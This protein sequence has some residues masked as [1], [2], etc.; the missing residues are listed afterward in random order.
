ISQY[1]SALINEGR[2]ELNQEYGKKVTWHDPCYLGRHNGIYDEPRGI[3]KKIPGVELKEMPESRE[4]SLCCGGGGGRIWME[5]PKD[6]RFSDLR[7][8]QAVAVGAEVLVT[9]CPYCITNFEDSRL[10]REDSEVI[11]IKDITEILLEVI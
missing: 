4:D 1:L 11:E 10:N 2:L 6:E 3:L 7:V 9:A 8:E 5:T